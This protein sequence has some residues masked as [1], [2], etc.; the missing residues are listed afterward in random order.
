VHCRTFL[1]K[2]EAD[3]LLSQGLCQRVTYQN[4]LVFDENGPIGKTLHFP[5]ECARHKILD[6]LGDFALSPFDWVGEFDAHCSG[7][8]LNADCVKYLISNS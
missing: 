8:Q 6:M 4:V 3:G 1:T 7:H 5:N 2:A